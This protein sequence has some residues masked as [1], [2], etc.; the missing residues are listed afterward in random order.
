MFPMYYIQISHCRIK[1]S[2]SAISLAIELLLVISRR[3]SEPVDDTSLPLR[4]S[5]EVVARYIGIV[6]VIIIAVPLRSF[7]F[8]LTLR[9]RL[10]SSS[11]AADGFWVLGGCWWSKMVICCR[12]WDSGC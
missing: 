9:V 5:G 11:G 1:Y 6:I 12:T 10:L 2:T 8:P 4:S 7:A 3:I